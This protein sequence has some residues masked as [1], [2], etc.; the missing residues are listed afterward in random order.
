VAA[1]VSGPASISI[2]T[3][4]DDSLKLVQAGV[5]DS[6]RVSVRMRTGSAARCAGS[7]SPPAQPASTGSA[8]PAAAAAPPSTARRLSGHRLATRRPSGAPSGSKPLIDDPHPLLVAGGRRWGTSYRRHQY[9]HMRQMPERDNTNRNEDRASGEAG[10]SES[11]AAGSGGAE[12]QAGMHPE[13]EGP[14]DTLFP[15][16]R[17]PDGRL[18]SYLVAAQVPGTPIDT[19]LA[20]LATAV[21]QAPDLVSR[22]LGR[23]AAQGLV[24]LEPEPDSEQMGVTVL[25]SPPLEEFGITPRWGEALPHATT[26]GA[27]APASASP[28]GRTGPPTTSEPVTGGAEDGSQGM[29]TEAGDTDSQSRAAARAPSRARRVGAR[30]VEAAPPAPPAANLTV[31]APAEPG[32]AGRDDLPTLVQD[33]VSASVPPAAAIDVPRGTSPAASE[34]LPPPATTTAP[35]ARAARARPSSPTTETP[36]SPA[37][38][39]PLPPRSGGERPTPSP[40]PRR[41]EAGQPASVDEAALLRGFIERFERLIAERD[42]W[43][44]RAHD[45]ERLA[46]ATEKQLRAAERRAETAEGKLEAAQERMRSWTDLTRQLQQLSRQADT[47]ARGR[48][49][50][51]RIEEPRAAADS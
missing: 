30:P 45:A 9:Y 33:S 15:P 8:V 23:L 4:V 3:P 46:A 43:R 41:G 44:Q 12:P 35:P 29:A 6:M 7:A 49:S 2:R 24:L 16:P 36:P 10:G 22:Q 1:V 17:S 19:S 51:P 5:S 37:I 18:L 48:T 31:T 32:A 20:S 27:R 13:A 26:G 47:V 39:P 40:A 28:T 38:A 34:S 25:V 50:R 14:A 21:R 42:E 11:K